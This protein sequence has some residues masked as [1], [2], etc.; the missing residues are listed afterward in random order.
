MS[1]IEMNKQEDNFIYKIIRII[2]DS[3]D[4]LKIQLLQKNTNYHQQQLN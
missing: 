3:L 2:G 1:D 4:D